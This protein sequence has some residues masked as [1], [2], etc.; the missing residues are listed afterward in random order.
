[1][2]KLRPARRLVA[3]AMLATLVGCGGRGATT[4]D[5]GRD[6]PWLPDVPVSTVVGNA[7]RTT[8]DCPAMSCLTRFDRACAGPVRPHTWHS[9]FPGGYCGPAPDVDAG[10]LATACP[11]GSTMVT[12]FIGCDGVPFRWCGRRCATDA[13]C[14]VA[15]GYRCHQDL[16]V[17]APPDFGG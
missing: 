6:A 15:E 11:A 13:D 7:C 8:D 5:A 12:V 14:R 2:S 10:T 1:M 17:C 16:G 3:L 4:T 9:E